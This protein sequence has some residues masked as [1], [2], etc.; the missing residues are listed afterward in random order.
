MSEDFTCYSPTRVHFGE[1]ALGLLG[2]ELKNYGPKVMLSYGGD[3]IKRSGIYDQLVKVLREAGKTIIEDGGVM[4]NPVFVIHRDYGRIEPVKDEEKLE[5]PILTVNDRRM[6]CPDIGSV[7]EG[8]RKVRKEGVDLILAVGGGLMADYAKAV[9]ASAY[10]QRNPWDYYFKHSGKLD[11]RWIPV[12]VVLTELGTGSEMNSISFISFEREQLLVVNQFCSFETEFV[13]NK[14]RQLLFTHF[15]NPDFAILSPEFVYADPDSDY[16]S[17]P[18]IYGTMSCLLEQYLSGNNDD[19]SDFVLEGLMQNLIDNSPMLLDDI[20]VHKAYN[21]VM[22]TA[23][24]G[25]YDLAKYDNVMNWDLYMLG[26]AVS[27]F[28]YVSHGDMLSAVSG[29]YYRLL[30]EKSDEV[31]ARFKRL[32]LKVWGVRPEG[33]DDKAV[34]LEG[35]ESMEIWMRKV[36]LATTITRI[37]AKENDIEK[38][39]DVC[40]RNT[41]GFL[42]L[43]RDEVIEIYRRCL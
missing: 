40:L 1:D 30:M 18:S 11:S 6:L 43:T 15:R 42:T 35:L 33:K 25:L 27:A 24:W 2:D 3:S 13:P 12:G 28:A 36:G 20:R 37:G 32:A 34:A 21:D 38:Y 8:A 5:E 7:L 17:R 16:F 19:T 29:A 22:W 26:L 4:A 41:A 23:T 9:S 14:D 31:L 10:Q 39:A